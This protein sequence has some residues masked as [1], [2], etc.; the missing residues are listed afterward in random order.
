ML[1][2]FVVFVP[3]ECTTSG[4]ISLINKDSFTML[5]IDL[6]PKFFISLVSRCL[7][8]FFIIFDETIRLMFELFFW[9]PASSL[10]CCSIPANESLITM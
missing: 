2:I 8:N 9:T 4:L 10:T 7:S 1:I 6:L 5:Y 3:C